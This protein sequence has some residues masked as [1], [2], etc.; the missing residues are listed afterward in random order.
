MTESN[1]ETYG[2]ALTRP[3]WE[4]AR[5]HK[6]LI[7]YCPDSDRYQFYPRPFDLATGSENV[8]WVE[9]KGTGV[10]HSMTTVHLKVSNLLEPPYVV[11]LVELD[12]G[13]RMT[14]NII[15]G[16]CEIGDRVELTWFERDDGLPPLPMF[17]PV[18]Q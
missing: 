10:V 2:D 9:A 4:A 18:Q 17:R 15:G 11:A 16:E 1:N 6:L 8:E 12:E 5:Q 7:Q 3:F 13:V 14:T